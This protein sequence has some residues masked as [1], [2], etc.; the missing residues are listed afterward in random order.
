MNWPK[1]NVSIL[2]NNNNIAI[3]SENKNN[4]RTHGELGE[5]EKSNSSH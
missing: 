4:Q 3:G 1:P 5:R 2:D